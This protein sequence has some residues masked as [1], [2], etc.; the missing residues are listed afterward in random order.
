M[1]NT[2]TTT[3]A[4]LLLTAILNAPALRAQGS[5]CPCP[6]PPAADADTG[7]GDSGTASTGYFHEQL[8]PY[9]RGVRRASCGGGWCPHG[10]VGSRP[11]TTRHRAST[12]L[13]AP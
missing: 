10:A 6:C 8:T 3:I 2:T 12:A 4:R 13:G 1:R 5:D 9:G 11:Y 7:G